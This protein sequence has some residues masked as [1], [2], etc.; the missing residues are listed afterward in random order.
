MTKLRKPRTMRKSRRILKNKTRYSKNKS[1]K[2]QL[3]P[4]IKGGK[5]IEEWPDKLPESTSNRWT[6]TVSSTDGRIRFIYDAKKEGRNESYTLSEIIS[7]YKD[8]GLE[9][10]YLISYFQKVEQRWWRRVMI[11]YEGVIDK[12]GRRSEPKDD[13]I[14]LIG[15]R[16]SCETEMEV[17]S[18]SQKEEFEYMLRTLQNLDSGAHTK[19]SAANYKTLKALQEQWSPPRT[20]QNLLSQT[21]GSWGNK[22]TAGHVTQET[23]WPLDSQE[24]QSKY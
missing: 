3:Y 15:Q 8:K 18:K 14:M 7:Y 20:M 12:R 24:W 17:P 10:Q 5:P 4:L 13:I 19:G 2:K 11:T 21:F 9:E 16:L 23:R 22:P 6:C 1:T